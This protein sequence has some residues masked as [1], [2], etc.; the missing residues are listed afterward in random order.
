[1]LPVRFR[2]EGNT[3]WVDAETRNVGIGGAFIVTRLIQTTGSQL[4]VE[5]VLPSSDQ[6]F[7][8]PSI[9]R[10]AASDGMGVQFVGVDVD[11]L[12]ELNDYFSTLIVPAGQEF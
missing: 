8:L 9:V 11:V 12:L 5:L 3:A 1:V 2:T 4:A 6:A 10:W 7:S